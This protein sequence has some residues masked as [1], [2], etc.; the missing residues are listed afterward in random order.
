MKRFKIALF[1]LC[2][3]TLFSGCAQQST[4][5]YHWG[6]Y[7]NIIYK[8]YEKPGELSVQEQIEMLNTDITKAQDKGKKVSP[9]LYAHLG[10]LY[11]SDGDEAAALQ[12][13][14]MEQT[15][16]PESSPFLTGMIDRMQSGEQP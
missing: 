3:A 5:I 13:F 12:A 6:S 9:G 8:S 16:F 4:N 10:Y 1:T 11:F 15:L 2:A 14:N 7:E